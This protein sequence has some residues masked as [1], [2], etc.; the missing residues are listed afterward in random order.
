MGRRK[1]KVG[2]SR[3][4]GP[5]SGWA[6]R[7]RG[8]PGSIADLPRCAATPACSNPAAAF[9]CVYILEGATLGGRTLLPLVQSRLGLTALTGAAF[10]ASYGE[11]VT[12][13]WCRFGVALDAWCVSPKR[14]ADASQAAVAT[15]RSAGSLAVRDAVVIDVSPVLEAIEDAL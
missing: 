1:G 5:S 8:D 13:M 4:G 2:R 11:D 10:L 12:S 3:G 6:A 14:A 15:F 7:T 9:G